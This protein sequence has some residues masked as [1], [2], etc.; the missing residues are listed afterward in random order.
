MEKSNLILKKFKT[1]PVLP[2]RRAVPQVNL[3]SSDSNY[4]RLS[5]V[6]WFKSKS[7]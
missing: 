7:P 4:V 3:I 6:C 1:C 2:I 5:R